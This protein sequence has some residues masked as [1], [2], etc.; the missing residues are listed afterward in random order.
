MDEKVYMFGGLCVFSRPYANVVSTPAVGPISRD[1]QA[2]VLRSWHPWLGPAGQDANVVSTLA[3]GPISRD[4]QALG[5]DG[6][7]EGFN[8]FSYARR[9]QARDPK[10]A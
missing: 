9:L 1:L 4:L 2:W 10:R 3:V 7:E 6:E 5:R 8:K